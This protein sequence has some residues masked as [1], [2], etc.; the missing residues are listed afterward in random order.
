[1]TIKDVRDVPSSDLKTIFEFV[2]E[3]EWV[4]A[5]HVGKVITGGKSRAHHYLYGY[6]GILFLKRGLTP[7][8][9]KVVSPDAFDR[10]TV[11]ISSAPSPTRSKGPSCRPVPPPKPSPTAR[12]QPRDLFPISR[13]TSLYVR[14]EGPST[15]LICNA[16]DLPIH[17]TGRCGCS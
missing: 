5:R 3:N 9:W 1:M 4:T 10:M 7:P 8:Q 16:C 14:P 13:P 6:S 15:V 11:T 2:R 12:K 17:S